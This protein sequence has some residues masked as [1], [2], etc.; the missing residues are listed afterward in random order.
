MKEKHLVKVP[1]EYWA[2]GVDYGGVIGILKAGPAEAIEDAE[3]TARGK[4]IQDPEGAMRRMLHAE[5]SPIRQLR[6]RFLLINVPTETSVHFVRSNVGVDS[7]V[8]TNRD[9]RGGGD[10]RTIHRLSPVNHV[11]RLNGQS[12]MTLARKRLCAKAADRTRVWMQAIRDAAILCYPPIG[13]FLVP[14]C[15]YRNGCPEHRGCGFMP[16]IPIP[17]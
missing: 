12:L 17:T 4:I 10:P 5:H 8:G 11:L 14:T 3:V 9:D 7:Y 2:D 16:A 6:F 15:G 1:Q 13:P